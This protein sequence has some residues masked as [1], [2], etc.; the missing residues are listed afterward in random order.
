MLRINNGLRKLSKTDIYYLHLSKMNTFDISKPGI[1]IEKSELFFEQYR[2]AHNRDKYNNEVQD[3]RAIKHNRLFFHFMQRMF[4]CLDG[5][6]MD[7]SC[8]LID[9]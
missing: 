2:M 3:N 4:S 7:E 6:Y 9:T 8:I 5:L 1:K